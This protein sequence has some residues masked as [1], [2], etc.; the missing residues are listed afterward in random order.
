MSIQSSH[1]VGRM[2]LAVWASVVLLGALFVWTLGG[3]SSLALV[4]SMFMAA[5]A[6]EGNWFYFLATVCIGGAVTCVWLLR[7]TFQRLVLA[8]ASIWATVTVF[9]YFSAMLTPY[10]R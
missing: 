4:P 6:L 8:G 3:G 7:P 10:G 2:G 5:L 9:V 1:T